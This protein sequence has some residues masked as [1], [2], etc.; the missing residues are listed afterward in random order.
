MRVSISPSVSGP[1]A[2]DEMSERERELRGQVGDSMTTVH[3]HTAGK[4]VAAG[5]LAAALLAIAQN[6]SADS[7]QSYPTKYVRII[8]GGAGNM[9]DIVARQLGQRLSDRWGQSVVIENR[10]GG[11]NTIATGKVARATPDGYTLAISD[12]TAL[13]VAPSAFKHLSYDP[14]RDLAPITLVA[15]APLLIVA[16][17]SIP[18]T[19]LHELI[20]YAKQRPGALSYAAAAQ[21]TVNHI[22]GELFK[23][24]AGVEITAVHYKGTPAAM[25]AVVSGE[26]QLSFGMVPIALPHVTAGKL[27]AYAV[28]S[29]KRF[30]GL[31]EVPTAAEAGLVGFE[32]DYWIGMLAPARTP[33]KLIAKLNSDVVSHLRSSEMQESLLGQGAEVAAGTSEEFAVFIRSETAR[34]KKVVE[35]AGIR[36]N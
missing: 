31:P 2:A 27:K 1:I 35:T 23:Q 33:V 25:L 26:V 19:K 4:P 32:T 24:M 14:A 21:A 8:T 13:A 28:T 30:S 5:I 3:R 6:S 18:A 20:D 29:N 12:R 9:N 22:A 10:P 36:M 11:G 16:H 34:L 15:R 17:P 7:G